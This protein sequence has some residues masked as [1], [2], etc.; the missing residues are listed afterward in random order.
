MPVKRQSTKEV[1]TMDDQFIPP[2]PPE[3]QPP[4]HGKGLRKVAATAMLCAGLLA[5]SGIGGF[6]IAHA[7][8]TSSTTASS[9]ATTMASTSTPSA[10]KTP[11]TKT[12]CPNMG[13]STGTSG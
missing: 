13:T 1:H 9:S 7:A 2:P 10:T 11:A 5:G 3:E 4:R 12:G 8:G 6:A